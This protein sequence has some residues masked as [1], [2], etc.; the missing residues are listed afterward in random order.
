MSY[1]IFFQILPGMFTKFWI[2]ILFISAE[3]TFFEVLNSHMVSMLPNLDGDLNPTA[4]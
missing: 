2:P 3:D 4:V 1:E